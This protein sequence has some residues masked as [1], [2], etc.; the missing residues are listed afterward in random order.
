MLVLATLAV[1]I[2]VITGRVLTASG[3]WTH[4]RTRLAKQAQTA[5]QAHHRSNAHRSSTTAARLLLPQNLA[6]GDAPAGG[7]AAALPR[8]RGTPTTPAAM[9]VLVARKLSLQAAATAVA[10]S[11]ALSSAIVSCSFVGA[12]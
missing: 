9:G 10:V 6:G 7:S 2:A 1:I 12:T 3:Q 11:S 5:N 8:L 4:V